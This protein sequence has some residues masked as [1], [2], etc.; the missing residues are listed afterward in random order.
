MLQLIGYLGCVFLLVRGL[1]NWHAPNQHWTASVACII[2][3][4][5]S[6]AFFALFWAQGNALSSAV[7]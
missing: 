7:G 5:G 2:A 1:E 4:A 6:V 3:V